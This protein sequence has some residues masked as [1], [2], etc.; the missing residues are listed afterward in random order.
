LTKATFLYILTSSLPK[1]V[2]SLRYRAAG[3]RCAVN[4]RSLHLP[5]AQNEALAVLAA[6]GFRVI[7]VDLVALAKACIG[8]SQYR[9]GARLREAPSVLDCSSLIKWLYGQRGIWL[10][11]RSIQQRE[12]GAVVQPKDVVA[13]DV[14]FISGA[15]DYYLNDASDGVGHVG[16]ATGEGT[17]IHAANR[18]VG[19]AESSL[20]SFTDKTKFR[21]VR[22]YVPLG[23]KVLTFETPA[24]RE[25]E[26]EDDIRWIVLQALK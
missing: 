26:I 19:I 8:K 10:P 2:I 15:I 21:G 7:D 12:C 25:V 14:V 6:K 20:E 11:R 4:F 24:G 3:N 18:K 1:E 5:I 23:E 13:G 16:I 22:R 9:R 17:V